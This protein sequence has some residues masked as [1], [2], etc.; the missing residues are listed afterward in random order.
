MK[1]TLIIQISD[2]HLTSMGNKPSFNQRLDPYD[3]LSLVFADIK[4]IKKKPEFI[5]VTGDLIHEGNATDYA[6]LR[7]ILHYKE[8][9]LGTPIFVLLG[10]HDRTEAF[11]R[12]FLQKSVKNKY[13][14]K[15][16]VNGKDNYFLDTTFG[17]IEQGYLDKEQL[18]WLG[19]NLKKEPKRPAL[20]FMHH[21]IA[22]ASLH[23]MRFSVLQN[24]ADLLRVCRQGN[25]QGIFSGHVHFS[26]TYSIDGILNSVAESTAYHIDCRD[27][28]QH[29][30]SDASGY[31]IITLSDKMEIG[32]ENRYL[33]C[34][35]ETIKKIDVAQ[36]DFI[37]LKTI[38]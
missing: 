2:T 8:Q 23:H 29:Y 11:Y 6:H 14:H 19:E 1:D 3:K 31:S 18:D 30:V 22:G 10:N 38:M 32:V 25:I 24:G 21:P 4:K 12:G 36:T 13:Y 26:T 7:E 15:V 37:D 20:I 5:V 28:H 35:Q 27:K 16:S 17:N 34:G 9:E 33:Y